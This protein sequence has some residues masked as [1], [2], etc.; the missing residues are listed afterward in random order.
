MFT[1]GL[2][3]FIVYIDYVNDLNKFLKEPNA[4]SYAGGTAL[5]YSNTSYIDVISAIS[6]ELTN[7]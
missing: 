5:F 6:Y 1:L 3:Q 4:N 2:L 7:A